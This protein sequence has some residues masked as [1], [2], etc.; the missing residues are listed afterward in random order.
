MV[1]LKNEGWILKKLIVV[2]HC[3]ATGQERDAALT[4]AGEKQAHFLADFLILNNLQIE[5]IISSPF[6]RAIQSI[7]PFAL[8]TN[9]PVGEDERLEERILS[10]NPMEDWLQK[11]EYT[12][13]NIDIAFLGGESTKQAMDRV[14]SL[15]QDI[16][17]QEH[18]VTLL[19]T[20]GNLLTL[21]LK[22]FDNRIGFLEWKNLSNPDIYEI[23]LDE[24]TTIH[25]LWGK[26]VE[27]C[28]TR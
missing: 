14:A 1:N 16:L 4:I 6:T 27:N 9:L 25:R 21:I 2:R 22:Y 28:Y 20:H 18:Q 10:N 23:T 15:I 13:T 7:A 12:F 24:Q 26:T 11:L 3:S 8:R 19:V 17:Q 5:S